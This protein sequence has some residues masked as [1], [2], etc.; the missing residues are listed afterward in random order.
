[1]LADFFEV[2]TAREAGRGRI[3]QEQAHALGACG[4]VGLGG[5]HQQVAVLAVADEDLAAVD[6]VV[7]AVAVTY[8]SRRGADGLEVAA[9]AGLGHADGGNRL[10]AGHARQ[11]VCALRLGAAVQQVGRDDV[12]VH[13]QPADKAAVAPAREHLDHGE[14][15][16][17]AGARAA[18]GIGHV[19]AEVAVLAHLAQ[20]FARHAAGFFPGAVVGFDLGV[21]E[22]LQ[23]LGEELQF[24]LLV[25]ADEMIGQHGGN[26]AI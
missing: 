7:V 15:E 11:P 21:A 14:R 16:G 17:H 2:L 19:G 12:V 26:I 6:D 10:A 8:P 5:E 25:G 22:A 23:R 18:V 20:Q 3:D 9:R 4:R 1:M 24:G 13:L